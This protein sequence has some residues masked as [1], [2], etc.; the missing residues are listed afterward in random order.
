MGADTQRVRVAAQAMATR[1]EIVISGEEPVRARAAGEAALDEILRIEKS[2]SFFRATSA[3][4]E[5]NRHA[6]EKP[7]R[8]PREV[9]GLLQV[10]KGLSEATDGA[11]DPTIGAAMAEFRRERTNPGEMPPGMSQVRLDPAERT[12]RY[13]EKGTLLDLGGIGKGHAID[14]ATAVLI[15]AGMQNALVHGGTSTCRTLGTDS[16]SP[17]IIAISHPHPD[18]TTEILATFQLNNQSLSV[19]SIYGRGSKQGNRWMGHVIDPRT[20]TSV[21]H[22]E[23]AAV[24]AGTA[25]TSDALSTALLVLGD[26]ATEEGFGARAT[27]TKSRSGIHTTGA[28][29][30]ANFPSKPALK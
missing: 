8:P 5:L 2:L 21:E 30:L 17:W 3:L 29:N 28:W 14:Q 18:R 26:A 7:V 11:F 6:F 20:G 15:E 1:F 16:G 24:V 12:V 22:T 23:L 10:A 27:L 13:L 19:S 25:T 4:S 9:F